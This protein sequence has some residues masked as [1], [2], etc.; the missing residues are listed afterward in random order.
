M[1]LGG[2]S[3][4]ITFE[5]ATPAEDPASEVRLRLYGQHYRV[6]THS[7]LCY[8]RDQVLQRLLASAL[9]VPLHPSQPHLREGAEERGA[10]C[11][12]AEGGGAVP[13]RALQLG[14]SAGGLHGSEGPVL[15]LGWR[16]EGQDRPQRTGMPWVAPERTVTLPRWDLW[17]S[18][19]RS[20][21][22]GTAGLRMVL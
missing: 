21:G 11:P 2:A 6:Y 20:S 19:S 1:D 4:Q 18:T 16:T 17:G 8:G 3:T 10:K 22:V 5:T 15:G 7:F 9:Q 14:S 12:R 13:T